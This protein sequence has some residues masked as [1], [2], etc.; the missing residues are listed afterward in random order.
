MKQHWVIPS[1]PSLWLLPDHLESEETRTSRTWAIML[2]GTKPQRSLDWRRVTQFGPEITE[3]SLLALLLEY[4][5]L[6]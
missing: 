3:P 2:L 5:A 1:S 4:T 6:L